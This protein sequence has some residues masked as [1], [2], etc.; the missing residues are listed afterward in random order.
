MGPPIESDFHLDISSSL[1]SVWLNVFE[2]LP[3][4]NL[5]QA[6]NTAIALMPGKGQNP[7]WGKIM[8]ENK[9]I[10]VFQLA[11]AGI[12]ANFIHA[13]LLDRGPLF[14]EPHNTFENTISFFRIFN[15]TSPRRWGRKRRIM[16]EYSQDP[17]FE[18]H[19]LETGYRRV[20]RSLPYKTAWLDC[21]DNEDMQL[22]AM[23]K[24]WRGA[25]KKA[26]KKDT[27]IEWNTPQYHI[28]TVLLH[29][30]ADVEVRGYTATD[31]KTLK[32]LM[33]QFAKTKELWVGRM[34]SPRGLESFM[35]FFKHGSCLTYQAGWSSG[36]GREANAHHL[37]LWQALGKMREAGLKTLDLGGIN[38]DETGLTRFKTG[39]G[40]NIA[41]LS[42]LYC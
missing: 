14:L 29:Y 40:A 38:E 6:P 37:I 12:F 15:E 26:Q 13:I 27:K 42:P 18:H 9:I 30:K 7:L 3:R 20:K 2:N 16:P 41:E 24:N 39:A 33:V 11:Q 1:D 17:E 28:K 23:R 8:L 21:K 32:K 35:V 10:G 5:L 36:S 19:L 31:A 22:A 34:E 25:L 4:S